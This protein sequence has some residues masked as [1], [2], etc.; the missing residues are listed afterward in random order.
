VRFD[1]H[2]RR[3]AQRLCRK[4]A[5]HIRAFHVLGEVKNLYSAE[6]RSRQHGDFRAPD[7]A[8]AHCGCALP[9]AP[10]SSTGVFSSSDASAP[11]PMRF[12]AACP[13]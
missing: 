11:A 2:E 3:V 9:L 12:S 1:K 10:F 7:R 5:D 4:G 6:L 13:K 8:P